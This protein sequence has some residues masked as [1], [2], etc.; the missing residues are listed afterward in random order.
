MLINKYCIE[1]D[2]KG[3]CEIVNMYTSTINPA[4]KVLFGDDEFIPEMVSKYRSNMV[5]KYPNSYIV[6]LNNDKYGWE[7]LWNTTIRDIKKYSQKVEIIGCSIPMLLIEADKD[8]IKILE[9]IEGIECIEKDC[10]GYFP[11]QSSR[12]DNK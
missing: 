5:K 11:V 9:N 2:N 8:D 3:L 4:E 6:K 7:F 10:M 1:C 12:K